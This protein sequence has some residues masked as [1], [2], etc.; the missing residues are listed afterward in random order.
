MS[1]LLDTNVLSELWR[2]QP[3]AEV[4]Q[5]VKSRPASVLH[6]SVLSVGDAGWTKFNPGTNA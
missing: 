4:V 2:K 3:D 1:H 6:L 5:S